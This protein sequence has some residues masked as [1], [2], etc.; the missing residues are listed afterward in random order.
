M[1]EGTYA[2]DFVSYRF[3]HQRISTKSICGA[4]KAYVNFTKSGKEE[5]AVWL[6]DHHDNG[7]A[8][9]YASYIKGET[10]LVELGYMGE[11]NLAKLC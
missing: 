10:F 11:E 7:T 9:T 3:F 6:G 8:Y 1:D 5:P 4:L 2:E